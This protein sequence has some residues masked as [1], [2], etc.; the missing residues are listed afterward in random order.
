M[1]STPT[2]TTTNT[3]TAAA[4]N[5]DNVVYYLLTGDIGGTNSRLSLYDT[6]ST[7]PL[8][9]EFYR[10]SEHLPTTDTTI[11]LSTDTTIFAKNILHP[12]LRFCFKEK[13]LASDNIANVK[14]L[15]TLAIAGTVSNNRVNLTNLGN[16][17]VDGNAIVSSEECQQIPYL[18]NIIR[19]KIINDFV[20]VSCC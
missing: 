11:A 5:N 14:I 4:N 13:R 19:C 10:N 8:V 18:S 12:F 7:K 2:T 9:Q 1:T 6:V 16:I 15:A 17:L 20:A 3:P